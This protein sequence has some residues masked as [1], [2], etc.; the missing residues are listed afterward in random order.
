MLDHIILLKF[1]EST[2]NE[3]LQ[4]VIE[5][6]KSLKNHLWGVMDLQAGFNFSE[7]SQGFQVV[8]SIRFENRDALQA[9]ELNPEHQA[10]STYIREVGRLDGIVVDIESS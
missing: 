2:T 6:F 8:L 5:R 10:C 1:K 7:R 3:Q 9:Y 4:E